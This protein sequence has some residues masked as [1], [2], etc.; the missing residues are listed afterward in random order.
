[1]LRINEETQV[2]LE[3]WVVIANEFIKYIKQIK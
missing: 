1:M 2:F 3:I